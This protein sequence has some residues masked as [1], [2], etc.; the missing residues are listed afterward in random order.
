MVD[1][2]I[3]FQLT[4]ILIPSIPAIMLLLRKCY[5]IVTIFYV[6]GRYTQKIAGSSQSK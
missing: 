1:T 4:H 3:F 2:F 6:I 5:I